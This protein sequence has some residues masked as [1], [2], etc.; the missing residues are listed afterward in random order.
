[1][2]Q[3]SDIETILVPDSMIDMAWRRVKGIVRH[4]CLYDQNITRGIALSCYLQGL[5]DGESV[6]TRSNLQHD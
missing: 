5:V 6:T 3:R 1:M 2:K 4:S